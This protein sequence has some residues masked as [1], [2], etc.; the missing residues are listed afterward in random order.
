M[1][2]APPF[3][4]AFLAF[5]VFLPLAGAADPVIN[6]VT[7]YPD[8]QLQGYNVTLTA[9]VTDTD[10]DIDKVLVD[11]TFPMNKTFEMVNTSGAYGLSGEY[12]LDFSTDLP[13]LY[14]YR[15]FVNDSTGSY[16]ISGEYNFSILVID[17]LTISLEVSPSCGSIFSFYF[18]P[19]EVVREQT[20]FF[21]QV[22]ENVGNIDINETSE[23]YLDYQNGNR[24]WGPVIDSTILLKLG[25][26]DLHYGLWTTKNDTAIGTYYWHGIT[27]FK[28][29]VSHSQDVTYPWPGYNQT[30]S[31]TELEDEDEDGINETECWY[32]YRRTCFNAYA[33]EHQSNTT[34]TSSVNVSGQNTSYPTH[35]GMVN[36]TG[37]MF[38]AYTFRMND[39]TEYCYACLSNDTTLTPNEC[40]YSTKWYGG[41]ISNELGNLTVTQLTSSGTNVTFSETFTSCT[42]RY[43]ISIC[44]VNYTAEVLECDDYIQCNGSLE[45]VDDLELVR[46]RGGE[47]EQPSPEP[48]PEPSPTPSPKPTPTPAP[49]EIEI[50][51]YPV[52]PEV[53]GMQ[54][55]LTPVEFIV[56]NL[57]G[58]TVRDITL[59]PIVGEN[60]IAGSAVVD[61]IAPRQKLNRTL[62]I[63][64]TY[65]VEPAVY[66]IPVQAID[67]DGDILDMT[68]FWFE[69]L[70]G[71]F[72]AKI[73]IVESP[74]EI[75]L[76]SDSEGEIPILVKNIGKKPL[77]G[78]KAKLE[79][80]ED[81]IVNFSS[82]K[83][84]LDLE[85]EGNLNLK[86]KTKTGPK[87]CNAML[88]IESIEDAYAFARIKINVAAPSALLPG[89]IPLIPLLT[90]IFLILLFSLIILRRRG[91]YV[92]IMYPLVSLAT[93]I[94]LIYIFLW[95]LG[96]VPLF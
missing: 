33:M 38:N 80:A 92:G 84:V 53:T 90:V 63:Q 74:A 5:S 78:V 67:G 16:V 73:K 36:A 52:E 10:G 24:V 35:H 76:D 66:A 60:W 4:L 27:D 26:D 75:I 9:N 39:C 22:N 79:N 81:C 62:F 65:M 12:E 88:I 82:P 70:P 69:V 44:E 77:S 93:L 34:G 83:M 17:Q 91:K 86:V 11:F 40:A 19:E 46:R 47:E 7:D 50:N 94:L 15:I 64:P 6:G 30:A 45:I 28:G 95:Y 25:E 71:R 59:V 2:R 14:R 54:E 68:Y 85:E 23:M 61:I 72:L 89:G 20:V 57:G 32:H 51:I 29:K 37:D 55:Q 3:V 31:C 18:V 1:K 8:P 87:S 58:R 49:G 56:E 13:S 42:D 41:I 48:Y 21:I 96:Y 43:I